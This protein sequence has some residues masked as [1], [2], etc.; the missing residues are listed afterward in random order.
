MMH[1][2]I[3][4]AYFD[5]PLI[6]EETDNSVSTGYRSREE[7]CPV[8]GLPYIEDAGI[9]PKC[10]GYRASGEILCKSCRNA[11]KARL[12]AFL[13]ELSPNEREQLDLW[14]DGRSISDLW[15]VS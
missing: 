1:C 2:Q 10:N 15:K 7:L 8:C 13:D 9:C 4:N 5:V 6:Q 14:L 3:C 11:L 12:L